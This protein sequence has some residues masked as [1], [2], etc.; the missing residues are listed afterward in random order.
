M[1]QALERAPMNR[2]ELLRR[3]LEEQAER[4]MKRGEDGIKRRIAVRSPQGG[5]RLEVRVIK[6]AA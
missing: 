6:S 1:N 3:R 4:A 2:A 5:Y